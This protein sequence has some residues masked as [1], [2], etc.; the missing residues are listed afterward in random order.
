[1]A[2]Y[3]IKL[4]LPMKLSVIFP[5]NTVNTVNTREYLLYPRKIWRTYRKNHRFWRILEIFAKNVQSISD[6]SQVFAI[7]IPYYLELA[8]PSKEPPSKK[9]PSSEQI[10][11]KIPPPSKKP[12]HKNITKSRKITKKLRNLM[13]FQLMFISSHL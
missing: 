1:M 2:A 11:L 3:I 5:T 6:Y 13:F 8:P 12:P 9:P 7:F 4:L 10:N